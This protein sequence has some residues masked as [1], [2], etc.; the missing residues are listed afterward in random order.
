MEN[1]L[2]DYTAQANFDF[3]RYRYM[4]SE[5]KKQE[6]LNDCQGVLKSAERTVLGL[7]ELGWRLAKMKNSG[8]WKEVIN[9]ENGMSFNYSSFEDFSKYAFGFGKTRTSNLLSMAQFVDYDEKINTIV[10]KNAEYKAMNTS[11]LIEIAPLPEYQRDY[12]K[13]NMPV[14]DMRLCK[15]YISEGPFS[16]ERRQNDFNILL[17]AKAWAENKQRE[18]DEETARELDEEIRLAAKEESV[19]F[20]PNQ[21]ED[22][23]EEEGYEYEENSDVGIL[24]TIGES[25][26]RFSSRAG[27]R[28]FLADFE[29][30]ET[31]PGGNCYS[32][33]KR[34]Q[35]KNG[36]QLIAAKGRASVGAGNDEK[37]FVFF[38]LSLGYGFTPIKTSKVRL[39]IW[40][41]ENEGVLL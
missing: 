32:E 11:Q 18:K 6:F 17:N 41:K 13:A 19:V 22:V 23:D 9:P 28:A 15:K 10:Y 35:F 2:M 29:D 36:M 37:A 14:K 1:E 27:V 25:K 38:F 4:P 7:L 20:Y 26:Y 24:E 30:W 39:E 12:F 8:A 33:L 40:L 3:F 34:Y 16:E 21:E 5:Q 31:L